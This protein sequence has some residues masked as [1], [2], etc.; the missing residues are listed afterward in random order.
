MTP[1]RLALALV[2]V[3]VAAS[4]GVGAATPSATAA[5]AE[6]PST[7][8]G[9]NATAAVPVGLAISSV[10]QASAAQA[11]GTVDN[12]MWA[13]AYA[14]ASNDSEK[15]ALVER[16]YGQLNTTLGELKAERQTLQAQFRNGSINRT[17]YLAQLSTIVGRLA[18]LGEGIEDAGGLGA[19][20]GVNRTRLDELRS[21]AHTLSGGE[22]SRLARN[23]T[24]GQGPPGPSGL[25]DDGPPGQAGER[26][27]GGASNRS[28]AGGPGEDPG[29]GGNATDDGNG[30][31]PP[32]SSEGQSGGN[33]SVTKTPRDS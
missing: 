32:T 24:G 17:T 9:G 11:A 10:M 6:T 14:N 18:A 12:G 21:Q 2:L 13:A 15:R 20:V 3:V 22:V 19:E 27:P 31:G 5:G 26:G 29:N 7:P 33:S 1:R 23:L 25:F 28:T 16:R 8:T 30:Q 4:V